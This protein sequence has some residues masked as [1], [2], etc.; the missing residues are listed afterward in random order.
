MDAAKQ[1]LTLIFGFDLEF[2]SIVGRSIW[3]SGSACLLASLF[4]LPLAGLLTVWNFPGRRFVKLFLSTL[5]GFPA[6]VVGLLILMLLSRSGP[7]GGLGLLYSPQAMIIA[8]CVLVTPLIA[9]LALQLLERRWHELYDYLSSLGVRRRTAIFVLLHEEW[10]GLVIVAIGGFSRAIAELGTAMMV[11]GNIAGHSRVM[12]TAI[13]LEASKGNLGLALAL[14]LFLL[15]V[16]F[17]ITIIV[18]L[19]RERLVGPDAFLTNHRG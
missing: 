5:I 6:I 18:V 15:L 4:G 12:T 17:G 3:V 13:A 10:R 8:Q 14:G 19:V 2:W 7:L 16:S 9:A 1:A 11:G